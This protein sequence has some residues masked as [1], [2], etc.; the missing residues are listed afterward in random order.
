M[1]NRLQAL[2]KAAILIDS[3]DRATADA[4]LSQ[5]TPEQARA[6]RDAIDDLGAVPPAEQQAV[7]EEFFR[8][9]P[10]VPEKSP[11]GIELDSRL[12]RQLSTPAPRA[13]MPTIAP[14]KTP[15]SDVRPGTV[16]QPFRCLEDL[17]SD[18]L[19]RY[20]RR[21]QPQTIAVVVSHLTSQRAAEVMTLLPGE[22]Q[23]EV[24]LRLTQ[25]DKTDPE[26]LSEIERGMRGWLPE[27]S[28]SQRVR[29]AGL[30]TLR[31][32]LAAA[33]DRA[34]HNILQN[35]AQ[36]DRGLAGK[37]TAPAAR[38]ITFAELEQFD[39]VSLANVLRSAPGAII[40]LALAG[41]GN[42]F[43]HRV[44]GLVPADDARQLRRGLENLGPTR[45]SD[46]ETAQ[47]ELAAIA[48]RLESAGRRSGLETKHL[49]IAV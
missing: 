3:L 2:R 38:R 18:V 42:E 12:A 21:E 41:A 4:M 27:A 30:E 19:A 48:G 35:L 13:S 37:L 25:L 43:V 14:T 49:S 15:W 29:S 20:L 46:V 7:I 34:K 32:I 44:L 23:G 1:K 47:H 8:I 39:N 45:L 33:D 22:L 9:G 6:V 24:A 11:P 36:R 40:L 17:S 16:E 10:L 26:I 31:G 5:M 28:G